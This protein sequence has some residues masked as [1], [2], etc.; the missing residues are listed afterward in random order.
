[1]QVLPCSVSNVRRELDRI[2]AEAD[3]PGVTPNELRRTAAPN[4]SAAGMPF[5]QIVDVLGHTDTAMLME[6]Y[7][8]EVRPSIDTAASAMYR[9]LAE[10]A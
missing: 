7:R 1:M 6:V 8:H 9:L 2:T 10:N 5:E 3:V 4:L